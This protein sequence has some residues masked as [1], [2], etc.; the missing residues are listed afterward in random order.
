MQEQEL[1]KRQAVWGKVT[2]KK[3]GREGGRK[4]EKGGG[5]EKENL[6]LVLNQLL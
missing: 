6:V 4:T 3:R 2:Q 5:R 1:R